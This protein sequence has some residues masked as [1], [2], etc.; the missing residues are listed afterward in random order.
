MSGL[1]GHTHT[2]KQSDLLFYPD[3]MLNF[4]RCTYHEWYVQL[5]SWR[6]R[7]WGLQI[8]SYSSSSHSRGD[9]CRRLSK[10]ITHIP[11]QRAWKIRCCLS[12]ERLCLWLIVTEGY[13]L[14]LSASLPSTATEWD[15]RELTVVSTLAQCV[16]RCGRYLEGRCVKR[17]QDLAQCLT[18]WPVLPAWSLANLSGSNTATRLVH[19]VGK[20]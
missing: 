6:N 17:L 8:P 16:C 2:R 11:H 3:Q 4:P 13:F 14:W 1:C 18:S 12:K 9:D 20:C 19:R 10:H 5:W 7:V 15:S